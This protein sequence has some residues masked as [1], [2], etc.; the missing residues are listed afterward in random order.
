MSELAEK[1]DKLVV[2]N[3]RQYELATDEAE[4]AMLMSKAVYCS[5]EADLE[6]AL[7]AAIRERFETSSFSASEL[8]GEASQFPVLS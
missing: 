5:I 7:D 2:E 1:Y 8:P 3:L 6:R 4:K